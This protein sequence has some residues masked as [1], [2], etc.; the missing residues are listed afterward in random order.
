MELHELPRLG[1]N[2]TDILAAGHVVTIEPGLYYSE[3]GGI[4]LED[5]VAITPQGP[6]NLTKFEK[7]LEV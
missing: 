1:V 5:V 7:T 4:R 3:I 2:S 6:K